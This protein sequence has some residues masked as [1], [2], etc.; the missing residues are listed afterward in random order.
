MRDFI[1]LRHGPSFLDLSVIS[2]ELKELHLLLFVCAC[3]KLIDVKFFTNVF[4]I[5]NYFIFD[6]PPGQIYRRIACEDLDQV[7]L[8]L[9]LD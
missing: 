5:A 8:N 2:I 6:P 4:P 1:L 3:I 9:I 7:A